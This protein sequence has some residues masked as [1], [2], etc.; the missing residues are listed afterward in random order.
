ISLK[1]HFF[2]FCPDYIP[3]NVGV[4]KEQGEKFHQDAKEMKRRYQGQWDL[5]IMA[6]YCWSIK[7]E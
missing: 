7:R 5:Y 4:S 6:G 2:H 1:L 3:E